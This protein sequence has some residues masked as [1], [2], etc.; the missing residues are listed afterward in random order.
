MGSQEKKELI[1]N[2]ILVLVI[3]VCIAVVVTFN[4]TYNK[5]VAEGLIIEKSDISDEGTSNINAISTTLKNFRRIIDKYYIG[6]IDETK[7]MDE[8]I[9]GYIN[10][11]DDEYSEYM[12]KEEWADFEASALGNYVGI[13]VTISQDV[14]GNVVV[15]NTIADAPAEDAGLKAEDVL[16]EVDGESVL[17]FSTNDVARKIQGEEGTKVK[18]KVARGNEYIDF[19][20]ERKAIKVYHVEGEI[21]DGDVGYILLQTFDE[22]AAD[23]FLEKFNELKNKGA[24]KLIIDLRYN[25]GGLLEECVSI[26]DYM[27]D[28]DDIILTAIDA[29]GREDSYK[30]E[31]TEKPIDMDIVVLVNDYSASASEVLAGALK[32]NGEAIIVGEKTY[33]KGVIQN[34]FTLADGSILKLTISEYLTPNGTRINKIGI[35]PDVEILIDPEVKEGNEVVDSQLNK[36]IEVLKGENK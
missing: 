16:V 24:K 35:M 30:S 3:A 34:V 14:N 19:E 13:G 9:K 22:G 31:N 15:V 28:K 18:I 36:A 27:L 12:T 33:G 25:T 8:T 1:Y 6:E 32:D 2:F 17:G 29:E 26:A 5:Y 23:E 7:I 21:K 4:V 20:I 11:L 10:G